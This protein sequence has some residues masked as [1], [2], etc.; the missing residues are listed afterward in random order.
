MRLF[1]NRSLGALERVASH[2][3][4][5]PDNDFFFMYFQTNS[6]VVQQRVNTHGT[7]AEAPDLIYSLFMH[8]GGFSGRLAGAI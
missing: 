5:D 3:G 7:A 8:S 1:G 2:T 4:S 6:T